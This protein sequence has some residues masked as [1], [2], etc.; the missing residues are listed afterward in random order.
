MP[1]SPDKLSILGYGTMRLPERKGLIDEQR[2]TDQLRYAI[3]RGLNVV[4]TAMPYAM[5]AC[6]PLM[7]RALSGG[8]REKVKISTKLPHWQV[9]K[10]EDMDGLLQVQLGNLQTDVIDYYQVHNMDFKAWKRLTGLGVEQF[11]ADAKKDGRIRF[12][13]FSFHSGFEDFKQIVDAYDWDF[14]QVQ[15]NYLDEHNQ[16]G[17]AGLEYAAAK[18]LGVFVFQPLRGGNLAGNPAPAIRETFEQAPVKRSP[19][20]WALRWVWNRPEI[21]VV[22]SGMNE[23]DQFEENLRIASQATPNSMDAEEL[24]VIQRVEQLYRESMKVDCDGCAKCMPCPSG[25]DVPTCFELYNSRYMW[26]KKRETQL[27]YMARVGNILG[28]RTP[29]H[30]SLYKRCADEKGECQCEKICPRNIDIRHHLKAV[31]RE[32]EGP[33]WSAVSWV[34]RRYFIFRRWWQLRKAKR[35]A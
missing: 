23:E 28:N 1:K 16:A 10:S 30:A 15:Y 12:V 33:L 31:A 3:D 35:E 8:Y 20:E 32:F 14:C 4:D 24:S 17:T 21:T 13:G 18:G 6:E 2:A 19:A 26:G 25:V 34:Y 9:E 11:L 29:T 7:G 5:G 22:L 27:Q